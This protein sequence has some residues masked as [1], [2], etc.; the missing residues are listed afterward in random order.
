MDMPD[1]TFPPLLKGHDVES[2][3]SAFQT[4]CEQAATGTLGAGDVVWSRST[5]CVEIAIILEPDV[6]METAVQM[7]PLL[8]VAVGDSLGSI[9]PPQ[10]GVTFIWPDVVCVNGARAGRVRAAAEKTDGDDPVPGWM[11]VGLE[12]AHQ[13]KPDDPEPG[14]VPDRTWLSEEGCADLTRSEIIE[15]C[16]RHLLTWINIWKDDGFRPVHDSWMFR[17]EQRDQS[18]SIKYRDEALS[19]TFLGLDDSGNMLLKGA[20]GETRALLLADYFKRFEPTDNAS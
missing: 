20:D 11:V 17:N 14:E 2:T 10:V 19:G 1:P 6:D 16:S 3:A 13:R 5:T 18:I 7:L 12:L 4:A 8:T 15:S 9:T